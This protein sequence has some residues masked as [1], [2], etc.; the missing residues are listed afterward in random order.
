MKKQKLLAPKY[1]TQHATTTKRMDTKKA[2][3]KHKTERI[4]M[5]TFSPEV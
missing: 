5:K 4:K 1:K 2:L 3:L